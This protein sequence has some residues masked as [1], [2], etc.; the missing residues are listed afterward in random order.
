MNTNLNIQQVYKME[1][2]LQIIN[3]LQ[4]VFSTVGVSPDIVSLPQIVVVG[5]QSTGKSSVLESIVQKNFL[6]RGTGNFLIWFSFPLILPN[7]A[8]SALLSF[9]VYGTGRV[10]RRQNRNNSSFSSG[11]VTRRPLIIQINQDYDAVEPWGTFLH[12][13]DKKYDNFDLICE[14]II[15]DTDRVC[16]SDKNINSEPITLKIYSADLPTLTL[17]D[18]P[19]ITKNPVGDQPRDIEQQTTALVRKY[20]ENPNCIIL[21]VSPGNIDIANSESIKLAKEVSYKP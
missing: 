2:F 17:V 7:I 10:V 13:P 9:T 15:R 19:G 20:I 1:G 14:E 11:I 5:S 16:G 12:N 8:I 6:P 4:D 3:D 18:L 21:A